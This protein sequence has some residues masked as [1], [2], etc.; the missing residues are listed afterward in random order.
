MFVNSQG[1]YP[2]KNNGQFEGIQRSQIV[3][4]YFKNVKMENFY[5]TEF[6]TFS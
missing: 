4:E 1:E 2:I 6:L 3:G 5:Y